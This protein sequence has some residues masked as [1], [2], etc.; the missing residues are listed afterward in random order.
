MQI[1]T[2]NFGITLVYWIDYAFSFRVGSF[3]W[4]VPV[5]LQCVFLV[6]MLLIILIVPESPRWLAAHGRADESLLVLRRLRGHSLDDETIIR[7]HDDILK[8]VEEESAMMSGSWRNI[9]KS[10]RIHSRRRLLIA[11]GIQ[12]F[13]QLGG[14]NAII[15]MSSHS[16]R[17]GLTSA[18]YSTTLFSN[19]GFDKHLS[20][21]MSGFLQL[22][23]FLASFIPWL[24]ID[25]LGRRPLVSRPDW[26]DPY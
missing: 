13:Q 17:L 23:L 7:L 11:C 4:R 1:S 24:L 22:W 20:A 2:L 19:V 15:C 9:L 16:F 5:I 12:A 21:L 14:I 18:D 8:A 3:A 25:R 10:D 26:S 6:P